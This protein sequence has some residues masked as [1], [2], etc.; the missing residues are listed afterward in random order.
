MS[1]HDDEIELLR[2]ASDQLTLG[3]SHSDEEQ[4]SKLSTDALRRE[5]ARRVKDAKQHKEHRAKELQEIIRKSK[6]EFEQLTGQKLNVS[7]KEAPVAAEVAKRKSNYD[8]L[9]GIVKAT[10]PKDLR[11][12]MEKGEDVTEF[13]QRK[14]DEEP[15][16]KKGPQKE[17]PRCGECGATSSNWEYSPNDDS[18]YCVCGE[19]VVEQAGSKGFNR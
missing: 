2:K 18:M 14:A 19:L 8:K 12:S 6:V 13:R 10:M 15:V 16:I 7:V 4:L 1:N 3:H 9:P 11:E 17:V 5:L